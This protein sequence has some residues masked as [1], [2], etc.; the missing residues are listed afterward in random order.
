MLGYAPANAWFEL[1]NSDVVR[2]YLVRHPQFTDATFHEWLEGKIA[3]DQTPGCRLREVHC[4]GKLGGWCGVQLESGEFEMALVLS[5]TCWGRG[6]EIVKEIIEWARELGHKQLHAHLPQS[7]PQTKAL[8]KLFGPPV[9]VSHINGDVF[10]TYR[11][12]I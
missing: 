1:L 4:D 12:E 5:P 3:V 6:Q 8:N 7:R 2:K 9:G 10:S 11:I